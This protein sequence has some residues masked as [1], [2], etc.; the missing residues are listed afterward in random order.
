MFSSWYVVEARKMNY[1]YDYTIQDD[2]IK[3][4]SG[5]HVYKRHEREL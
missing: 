5:I 2:Y 4:I 1:N 3:A